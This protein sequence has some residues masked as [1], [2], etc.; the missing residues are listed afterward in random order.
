MQDEEKNNLVD[1]NQFVSEVKRKLDNPKQ[2]R[3][4]FQTESKINV[5][6]VYDEDQDKN[7]ITV[8]DNILL[9]QCILEK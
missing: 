9:S 8:K 4:F 6:E 3:S 1:Q 7:E 2:K 5:S